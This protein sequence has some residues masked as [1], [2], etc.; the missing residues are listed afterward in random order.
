MWENQEWNHIPYIRTRH[1]ANISQAQI[2]VR[3]CVLSVNDRLSSVTRKII[4]KASPKF[5]RNKGERGYCVIEGSEY[6]H[7]NQSMLR[8]RQRGAKIASDF[9]KSLYSLARESPE[10]SL[11]EAV[12]SPWHFATRKRER[13]R[14]TINFR[15]WRPREWMQKLERRAERRFENVEDNRAFSR[16]RAQIIA[17]R[18]NCARGRADYVLIPRLDRYLRYKVSLEARAR[19][20]LSRYSWKFSNRTQREGERDIYRAWFSW[21]Q[22]IA[23]NRAAFAHISHR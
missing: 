13:E 18:E 6:C 15:P 8:D 3:K 2:R 23:H 10:V 5:E 22:T 17:P 12:S 16:S 20:A 19:D 9:G 4:R 11:F 1:C 14:G 7:V 21:E